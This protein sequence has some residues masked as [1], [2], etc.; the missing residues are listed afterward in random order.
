MLKTPQIAGSLNGLLVFEAAARLG[1]FSLAAKELNLSQPAVSRHVATLEARLGCPLFRRSHNRVAP[2]EDGLKLAGAVALGFGHVAEAWS[3]LA[4]RSGT[5]EVVLACS[6]GFADQW[7]MPRFSGLRAAMGET[8][9]RVVTS[10]RMED[11]DFARID[12]AVVWN[13]AAMP[14]RP[15]MP[16]IPD[17]T[18]AV[19]SPAFLARH[20]WQGSGGLDL[21]ALAA[22]DFLHFSVS[23]S[24]FLTWPQYFRAAG[25]PPRDFGSPAEYNAYPFLLNAVLN[26][27]GVALGWR[28]LADGLLE[29]RRLVRAGPA[30]STRSHSYFLQHRPLTRDSGALEQLTRWF[31]AEAA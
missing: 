29:Q 24:D 8:Q 3:A 21:Q 30:V 9:V 12:A 15:A 28:G 19:C 4:A 22:K 31:A 11:L 1:S 6:Y 17:E 20:Q 7:L 14:D 5:D 25:L 23:G 27:E 10:D 2:T 13:P 18:V 16:L 26:G